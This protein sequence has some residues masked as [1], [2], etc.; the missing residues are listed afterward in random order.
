M[1]LS[2]SRSPLRRLPL[3]AAALFVCLLAFVATGSAAD[4][5]KRGCVTAVPKR[6]ST[7]R[8]ATHGASERTT[9]ELTAYSLFKP[10]WP[11]NVN[12]AKGARMWPLRNSLGQ[13]IAWIDQR[14]D[15]SLP[16]HNKTAGWNLYEADAKTLIDSRSFPDQHA[17]DDPKTPYLA[18]QGYACMLNATY[19]HDPIVV[20]F[21]GGFGDRGRYVG[22]RGFIDPAAFPAKPGAI[23]NP[24]APEYRHSTSRGAATRGRTVPQVLA[25][26]HA[27][28]GCSQRSLG[29]SE[30]RAAATKGFTQS[31]HGSLLDPQFQWFYH[32][33]GN[34]P[35]PPHRAARA[36]YG[37]GSR[38]TVSNP[39]DNRF[40]NYATFPLPPIDAS[41]G[42]P[43]TLGS[44]IAEGRPDAQARLEA[45]TTG[46][47]GGGIVRA[48]LPLNEHYVV[49][50]W[51]RYGDP[52]GYC[53][54]PSNPAY[55]ARAAV[56]QWVLVAIPGT[57]LEGWVPRKLAN[58]RYD[59]S[60]C[61]G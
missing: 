57:P 38:A 7:C 52:N 42:P 35:G 41:G 24:A 1:I 28:T 50:D 2:E 61:G 44:R 48:I 53:G 9:A 16:G 47:H 27:R 58:P 43:A 60:G 20:L 3:L 17:R 55:V 5:A 59:A 49:K 12:A 8:I 29:F 13:T 6:Q 14:W 19:V 33:N 45:D 22:V 26:D 4:A 46:I 37:A 15:P 10:D 18:I 30:P 11:L 32:Y 34:F 40:S 23:V 25:G 39:S 54:R 51:F 56:A 31:L 36:T 21:H